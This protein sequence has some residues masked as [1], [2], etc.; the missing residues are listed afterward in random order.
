L[1]R[2]F[3]LANIKTMNFNWSNVQ[4]TAVILLAIALGIYWIISFRNA[5]RN[6]IN[7]PR[8]IFAEALPLLQ[9]AQIS[10]GEATGVY[11]LEGTYQ[12]RFFQFKVIVDNLTA[13]KLPSLWLMVTRPSPQPVPQMIDLMARHRG[14]T[15]FS[16]FDLLQHRL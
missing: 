4:I 5:R 12:G 2:V 8:R 3:S 10:T 1:R 6:E 15:A 13:R 16:N 9:D 7:E 14:H 11:K